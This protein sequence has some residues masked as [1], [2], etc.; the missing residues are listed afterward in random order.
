MNE[1]ETKNSV[2]DSGVKVNLDVATE[3]TKNQLI[4]IVRE[5]KGHTFIQ[6]FATTDV[7]MNKGGR[8][9]TNYLF[10]NIVKD[11]CINAS[12]DFDYENSVNSAL[13]KQGENDDFVAQ[14]R[15]WGKHMIIEQVF[16][17]ELLDF[18][19]VYSR[20]IIE[21]DKDGERRFYLQLKINPNGGQKPVYRYKDTGLPVTDEDKKVMYSYM[22]PKKDEIVVL[23][24]YRIDNVTRIHINKEKYVI[25]N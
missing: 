17:I 12:L 22:P 9:N 16:D 5:Q 21:H 20:S 14:E 3:I 13:R 18:V 7:K 8:A 24:D 19:P 15:K 10:G 23:R 6:I 11:G 4:N 2:I 1:N 25:K